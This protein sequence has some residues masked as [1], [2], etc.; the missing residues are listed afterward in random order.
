VTVKICNGHAKTVCTGQTP[1]T[2][3]HKHFLGGISGGMGS[4]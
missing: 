4:R 3:V 2:F 1:R